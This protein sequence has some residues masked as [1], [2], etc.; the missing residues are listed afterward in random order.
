MNYTN[1]KYNRL[2]LLHKARSGGHGIGAIWAAVCDCGNTLEVLA[3]KARC[4]AIQSCGNCGKGLGIQ[5]SGKVVKQGIPSG[6]REY[7]SKLIR[8]SEA[9]LTAQ[10]YMEVAKRRC[11]CCGSKATRAEWGEER[12]RVSSTE[13]IALCDTC[14]TWRRGRSIRKFLE[15]IVRTAQCVRNQLPSS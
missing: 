2:T 4:G 5:G 10:E 6:H 9:Q 15:Y 1:K 14:S 12:P 7:F 13:L 11:L 8:Q 3:R